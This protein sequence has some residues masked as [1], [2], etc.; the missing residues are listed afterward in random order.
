MDLTWKLRK[1]S[2][3]QSIVV[4]RNR[5]KVWLDCIVQIHETTISLCPTSFPLIILRESF[6]PHDL[7]FIS[8]ISKKITEPRSFYVILCP[9]N[10]I[11]TKSLLLHL[12]ATLNQALQFEQKQWKASTS[13]IC[14]ILLIRTKMPRR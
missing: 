11:Q 5:R 9:D 1:K 13:R 4:E 6:L 3:G 8:F 14:L 7:N 12:S 10:F 2:E